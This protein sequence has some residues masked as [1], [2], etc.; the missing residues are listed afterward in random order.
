MFTPENELEERLLEA[1]LAPGDRQA[2]DAFYRS[3][4]AADVFVIGEI[5]GSLGKDG[6]LVADGAIS[7]EQSQA[8]DGRV[9]IPLFSSPGRIN[10]YVDTECRYIGVNARALF[11]MIEGSDALLNPG[12]EH[13]KELLA[14]EIA[15]LLNGAALGE[16]TGTEVQREIAMRV[17]Q[18][19]DYPHELVNAL[20]GLFDG[21]PAVKAAYLAHCVIPDADDRPHTVIGV[22]GTDDLNEVIRRAGRVAQKHLA[23]GDYVDF[24]RLEDSTLAEYMI[25][26]TTPFYRRRDD[27]G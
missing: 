26:E 22:A 1:A 27:A 3:L 20:R 16:R 23:R 7:I 17:G 10:D 2:V 19:T 8:D 6:R 11:E 25:R 14:G 18:P 5:D 21:L 4:L 9:V 15:A 12:S 13:G 24:V